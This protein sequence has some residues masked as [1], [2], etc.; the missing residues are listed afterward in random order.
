MKSND[1]AIRSLTSL[2]GLHLGDCFGETFFGDLERERLRIRERR[3]ID[4]PWRYT[5]DSE[6]AAALLEHLF[7]FG[8]VRQD[9]LARSFAAHMTM[10]RGYGLAALELLSEI[11]GGRYWKNL[12][13]K[14]FDGQGSFGNGAAMRVAPLGA[15]FADRPLAELA[16]QARL[17]AEITHAHP[18]AI[19]GAIAVAIGAALAAREGPAPER[20]GELWIEEVLKAT[21]PGACAEGVAR[22]LELPLDAPVETAVERL[23]NG[24]KISAADTAPLCLWISAGATD[25]AEA[26][27]MTVS[28]LGDRDTT[29]A[30][31]GGLLAN[32]LPLGVAEDWT[33][34]CE[35]ISWAPRITD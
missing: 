17:S 32:R 29:C 16:E 22:A 3:L 10:R 19:A 2:R 21:P 28:A 31:V 11:K 33:R 4:A 6:M 24:A 27:W 26:L 12:N 23:G 30:I 14:S 8:R 25:F 18:D 13:T 20:L 9:E 34:R 1:A 35:V 5:D 7:E 15:W